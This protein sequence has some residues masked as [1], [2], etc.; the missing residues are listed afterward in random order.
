MENE[1]VNSKPFTYTM[2]LIGGKWKMQILFCLWKSEIMRYSELKRS[3]EGITH[4]MLSN[5][6]KELENDRLII[7]TEYPQ[8][9]PKV[10]YKLSE[11]GKTLMPVLHSVC[12]WGIEH[13]EDKV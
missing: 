9:P 5:Q 8:V 12:H 13:M 4:K 7:R 1:S 3:L 11:R 10:E 2:S 6:L